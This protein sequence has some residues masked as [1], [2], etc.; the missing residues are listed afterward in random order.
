MIRIKRVYEQMDSGDGRR[1]FVERLW[2]RGVKKEDLRM[3]GWVKN[4]APSDALRK[5]F[6]HDSAKWEEFSQRYFTELEENSG[7]WKLLLEEAL[8]GTVTLLYSASD[9]MYNNAVAL[10]QFLEDQAERQRKR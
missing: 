4:V 9:Q 6:G 10:K 5:W 3:D 7:S 1:F 2:P 8:H